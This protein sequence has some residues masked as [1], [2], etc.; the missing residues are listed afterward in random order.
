MVYAL[1]RD[2]VAL[3]VVRRFHEAGGEVNVRAWP[4]VYGPVSAISI[5]GRKLEMKEP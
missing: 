5:R 1:M 2:G 4:K 3:G